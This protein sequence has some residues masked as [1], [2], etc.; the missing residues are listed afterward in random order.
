MGLQDQLADI[1]E[2]LEKL[3]TLNNSLLKSGKPLS[4]LE[5]ELAKDYAKKIFESYISLSSGD[6]LPNTTI[7]K[8][9][10]PEKSNNLEE[11][12][13]DVSKKTLNIQKTDTLDEAKKQKGNP[14]SD[15]KEQNRKAE[16][17]SEQSISKEEP[18]SLNDKFREEKED[19]AS[20]NSVRHNDIRTGITLNDRISYVNVLFEGDNKSYEETMSKLDNMEHMHDAL[21]FINDKIAPKFNWHEKE[22]IAQRFFEIIKLKI[23][24]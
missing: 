5:L 3:R 16:E 4:Y 9:E 8:E 19:V 13:G 1:N 18:I 22:E 14:S 24:D 23:A 6:E 20:L 2:I 15:I 21:D 12:T 11:T 7:K 17:S 10:L